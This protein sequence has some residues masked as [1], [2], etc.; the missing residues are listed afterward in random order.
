[1]NN[2]K[3]VGEGGVRWMFDRKVKKDEAGSMEW[4]PKQ[5]VEL[6]DKDKEACQKLFEALDE[7]DDVQEIYSN[8]NFPQIEGEEN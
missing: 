2:G 3:A 5:E 4:I 7:S 8:V 6:S 1:M